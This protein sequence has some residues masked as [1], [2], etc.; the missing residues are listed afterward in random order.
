[1]ES[2]NQIKLVLKENLSQL[3]LEI[4]QR[5]WFLVNSVFK[6]KPTQIAKS[7]KLTTSK[8]SKV[9]MKSGY[10]EIT[11]VCFQCKTIRAYTVH[12]Q[13]KF[14]EI[15]APLHVCHVCKDEAQK[16]RLKKQRAEAERII[17]NRNIKF[18]K[19]RA[20]ETWKQFSTQEFAV[21]LKMLEATSMNELLWKVIQND[22]KNWSILYKTDKYGLTDL[23][24]DERDYIVNVFF[25]DNLKD[26]ILTYLQENKKEEKPIS[27]NGMHPELGFRLVKNHRVRSEDD[28]PYYGDVSFDRDTIIKANTL[29]AYSLW[30]RENGDMWLSITPSDNILKSKNHPRPNGPQHIKD[31]IKKWKY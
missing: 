28:S 2:N 7:L 23:V 14:K 20:H 6:E 12:T 5:Y 11:S 15:A 30:R 3:E 24:K 25:L 13:S 29:Y 17:E 9:A 10:L 26:E 16:I 31:I 21:I 22:K 1:M 27:G 4:S 8:V 19:A 18:S